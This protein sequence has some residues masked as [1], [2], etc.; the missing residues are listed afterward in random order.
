MNRRPKPSDD[1]GHGALRI[2][3]ERL[4]Q[5]TVQRMHW[6][7]NSGSVKMHPRRRILYSSGSGC[8]TT[9]SLNAMRECVPREG[10]LPS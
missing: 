6:R 10:S 3:G 8:I 7:R 5:A 4:R 9:H 1:N 2:L